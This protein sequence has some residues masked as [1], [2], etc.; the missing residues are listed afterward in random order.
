MLYVIII[1]HRKLFKYVDN[2]RISREIHSKPT[3][4]IRNNAS[5]IIIYN[6]CYN[7]ILTR[8]KLFYNS[9]VTLQILQ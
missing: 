5:K 2:K 4:K 6:I 7:E 9:E 3:H 1:S 8:I